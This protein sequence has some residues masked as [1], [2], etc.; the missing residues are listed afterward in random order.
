MISL[1]ELTQIEDA[2]WYIMS[3]AR[4]KRHGFTLQNDLAIIAEIRAQCTFLT[5]IIMS[6]EKRRM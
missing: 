5:E 1:D 4:R 6:I 2:G 3:V